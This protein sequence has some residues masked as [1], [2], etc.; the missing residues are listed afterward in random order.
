M[1]NYRLGKIY[2]LVSDVDNH[3]YIG[4]TCQALSKRL[5]DHRSKARTK[6]K[7]KVYKHFNEI[8]WDNVRIV[9][10]ERYPCNDRDELLQREDY[11]RQLR[12]PDLN[13]KNASGGRASPRRGGLFFAPQGRGAL[14]PCTPRRMIR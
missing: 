3:K 2:K 10:I 1:V 9:L 8:G 7:R 11:H 13:D 12:K 5:C 6:R 4:S 14:P